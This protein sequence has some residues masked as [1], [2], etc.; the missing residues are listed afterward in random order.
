MTD[1]NSSFLL[2]R[3]SFLVGAG[4]AAIVASPLRA[5]VLFDSAN[6]AFRLAGGGGVA[7]I[8]VDAQ[9][10]PGVA[11]AARDLAEDVGRVF[12]TP[13]TLVNEANGLGRPAVLVGTL[14]RSAVIDA[15]VAAGKLDVAP[16]RGQWESYT[17]QTVADPMPG[18]AEALVIAGSDKRGTIYGIYALSEQI[19]VSP[20]YWWADVPVRRRAAISIRR[21]AHFEGP[22]AVKY[23]GVFLNDEQPCLGK[24]TTEKFG[25]MNAKFYTRL[26]EVLLRL[27]ANYLWPAMWD[28]AF[29]QDDADNARLADEY[30]IVMGTSHHEPMM[31]AHKEWTEHR[32]QYGNGEWNYATNKDA[33]QVFFREGIA[34]NRA[35]EVL[36]TV[37]MR[38]DGDVAM[39]SAGDLQADMR[40]LETIIADQRSI[41]ATELGRDASEVPQL[42][43]L[44]TEVQKFYDAGLKVPDDVTLLF[45]DDN[46][47]NLRR[48]PKPEERARAGGSGIYYHMDMNGGPFSYKWLNSNPLPKIWEQMN[49]AYRYG[50]NRIWIANVGDFKPLEIPI[51]FFLRLAWNP[52]AITKDDVAGWTQRWASREFGPEFAVPIADIVAKYA[53]Y[54]AWR[55]PELVKPE[56][57]SLLHYREAERVLDAWSTL[58]AQAEKIQSQLPANALEA[59][60]QLVL[61]PVKASAT[62]TELNIAAA[63][64]ALYAQQGRAS[65]NAEADYV[66]Q[67][68][69]RDRELT[70]YYNTRL[71][72]GKWNHLMDQ[73]HLGYFEWYSPPANIMPAV[74]ALRIEDTAEY[75]VAVEGSVPG[76][77]GYYLDPELP[78]FDSLC[79]QRHY[80]EVFPRGARPIAFEVAATEPW[81]SIAEG[82]PFGIGR[83]DRRFWVE[84]DWDKVGV[85][86]QA[87]TIVVT[88]AQRAQKIHVK[89]VKATA[90]QRREARGAFGGLLGPIAIAADAFERNIAVDGVRWERIADYGRAA[91]AAMSIFPVTAASSSDPR[92]APRLEY[93]VYLAKAGR[94]DIDLVT[95]PTLNVNTAHQLSVAVAFDDQPPRTI[96][97]FTPERR[98]AQDFLGE[99]FT[100][101]ARNNARILSASQSVASAGRHVLKIMMVD[102]TM[103]VQKIVIRSAPLPNSYF[104]P[105]E[106]PAHR[107]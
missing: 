68:F 105:P 14:G 103:V 64:N 27:R 46:V 100:E 63:R 56:T 11:R 59:Y 72:G 21:G 78:A 50:A 90:A 101:N 40:L 76:W 9:D 32:A 73:V 58:A 106:V 102:P 30:G 15:L 41:L 35:H 22:P 3:R 25:G 81:I 5:M 107:D 18:V 43:A 94:Y 74:A 42:W 38:G 26:F 17:L 99:A 87:G 44:F 88:G 1:S 71:A 36:V 19:G 54:N 29:A 37:G 83:G 48:L 51:E 82:K 77:P 95:N 86:E 10:F 67:L 31:R 24:W 23:R 13:A 85:G 12:G 66:R 62:A 53:K 8:H 20:W 33:L 84:I 4:S 91:G 97:V 57:F 61:H 104:G 45:T 52:D 89:A 7:P 49:L 16:I 2:S 75:A 28:N 47:G 80:F 98:A 70:E 65:A 39:T 79:R 96:S 60:Y 92:T 69:Q 6:N 55:K 34:R 93:P